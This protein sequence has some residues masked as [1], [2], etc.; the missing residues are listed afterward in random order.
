[1]NLSC[2]FCFLILLLLFFDLP[3]NGQAKAVY[4]ALSGDA[5]IIPSRIKLDELLTRKAIKGLDYKYKYYS[6]ETHMT[7]PMPAYYDALRFIYKDW[8]NNTSK[9]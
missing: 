3:S 4:N 7:E 8:R 9:P 6:T 2:N 1:M 5:V